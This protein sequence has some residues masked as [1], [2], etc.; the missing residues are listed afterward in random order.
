M[1]LEFKKG[2][3]VVTA[4]KDIECYKIVREGFDG[5]YSQ[6]KPDHRENGD[7]I[8]GIDIEYKIG[9]TFESP[10]ENTHGLY[11][12]DNLKDVFRITKEN[13]FRDWKILKV[14]I[15]KGTK[16]KRG[17]SSHKDPYFFD[18][19][20]NNLARVAEKIYVKELITGV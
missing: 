4:K 12:F 3:R 9:E 16:Y 18:K 13:D 10:F 2:A 1:C 7:R 17:I 19:D 11:L 15:P 8:L 14:I 5:F 20:I 6:W